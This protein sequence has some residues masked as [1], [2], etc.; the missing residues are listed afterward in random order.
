MDGAGAEKTTENWLV[1]QGQKSTIA[2]FCHFLIGYIC[3]SNS[4]CLFD[5]HKAASF[6]HTFSTGGGFWAELLSHSPQIP[7]QH[8]SHQIF[9]QATLFLR[10]LSFWMALTNTTSSYIFTQIT[11]FFLPNQNKNCPCHWM[12]SRS[13]I[14]F[15]KMFYVKYDL[16]Y[17]WLA[18]QSEWT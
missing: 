18:L 10:T 16:Q 15:L 13:Y 6:S 8:Q 7:C 1:P 4:V 12:L 17:R 3:V 14:N 2:N 9:V 11:I 5:F